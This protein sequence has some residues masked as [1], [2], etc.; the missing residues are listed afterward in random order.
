MS[1]KG[2]VLL[3]MLVPSVLAAVVATAAF[4]GSLA[5]PPASVFCGSACKSALTLKANPA[6]IKC[7]VGLSWNSFLHPYGAASGKG[8]QAYQKKYF[9][10]MKLIVADGRG[11]AT[12]ETNGID[13]MIAKGI[14]VL[15][16]SPQDAQALAPAVLRAEKK[17]IKVIASD[18]GV[19]APVVTTIGADNVDT[20]LVAGQYVAKILN[21]KGHII[22]LQGSLGA[23]PT[24]DRHKGFATAIKKYP[25]L[26]VIGSQTANYNRADGLRVMADFLQRFGKGK[27]DAV[28]THNDEMSLGAIQAIKEAGRQSEIKVVGIDGEV[29]ALK[30]LQAG[31][32]AGSVAYPL[33]YSEH[34]LAAAKVCAGESLPKRIKLTATLATKA[35]AASFM[36]KTF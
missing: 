11:D 27:I 4:G 19:N 30:A 35:N 18:R 31:T 36:G 13:D 22:E 7:T 16:I 14:N 6:S 9:P 5:S 10:N 21:G 2:K 24:I 23:S 26:K 29:D 3:G 17:G 8:S 15:I 20:G 32:Y 28:Y 1:I 33:T 34:M 12:I 25:G